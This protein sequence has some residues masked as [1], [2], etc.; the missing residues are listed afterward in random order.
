MLH[1]GAEETDYTYLRQ[2]ETPPATAT[3]VPLP[4]Y[5][6]VDLVA[7]SLSYYGHEVYEQHH[8]V[9]PDGM[10]YFG[11]LHLK[12]PYT[13]YT[14][15]VALRNSH[16]KSL[17]V[18]IGFGSTVFC[19]DNLALVADHVIRT[20]HTA[21]LKMRLPGLVG[22]LIEPI[23]E[24]REAQARKITHYRTAELSE[25]MADHIVLQAYREGIIN[26]TRIAEVVKEY[27]DPTFE[28]FKDQRTA[29]ALLNSFTFVL[30][31]K[32][33]ENPSVTT[34]LHKIIDGVCERV[35]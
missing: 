8:G 5:R 3:H 33:V 21:K 12:S 25:P 28:E 35:H 18:G 22:E 4:H 9:T 19:C 29:W 34:K 6:L 17:P 26:V 16:D 10:R 24:Q 20:K 11:V 27:T 13:G 15:M 7:H 23:A 30:T 14:D 2:M 1:A 32:I 31:G